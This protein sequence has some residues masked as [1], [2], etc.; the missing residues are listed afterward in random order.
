MLRRVLAGLSLAALAGL[1][2]CATQIQAPHPSGL[3]WSYFNDGDEAK[4]AFGQP[5]SEAVGVMLSCRPHSR[6]VKVSGEDGAEA[7]VILVSGRMKTRLQGDRSADPLTGSTWVEGMAPT[8]AGALGGFEKT[9]RLVLVS[10]GRSTSISA[11]DRDR[12]DVRRFFSA[13]T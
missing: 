6:A 5:N 10:E 7:T 12:A 13:C 9:G 2:A 11:T 4:L 3:K 8:G 1:L